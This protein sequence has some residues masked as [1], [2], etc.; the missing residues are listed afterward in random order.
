[1]V[2]GEP[3]PFMQ[4]KSGYDWSKRQ[5]VGQGGVSGVVRA[6]R[7]GQNVHPHGGTRLGRKAIPEGPEKGIEVGEFRVVWVVVCEDLAKQGLNEGHL[8]QGRRGRAA[9]C[10]DRRKAVGPS[11]LAAGDR[12]DQP[13][14]LT[15]AEPSP[16]A[17]RTPCSVSRLLD[18]Q[19]EPLDEPGR[20]CG[21]GGVAARQ[22]GHLMRQNSPQLS[23]GQHSQKRE[24]DDQ[25]L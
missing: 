20:A 18:R 2:A 6:V 1:M 3:S 9:A 8:D 5:P 4:A 7:F 21:A 15:Q 24:A 10:D 22:V 14:R 19:L 13:G 12:F 16:G 25:G 11:L 23:L 17:K